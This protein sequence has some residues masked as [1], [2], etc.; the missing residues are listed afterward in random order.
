MIGSINAYTA[1]QTGSTSASADVKASSA[2]EDQN[3]ADTQASSTQT[4][5][6]LARQLAD[7]ASRAEARDKTLSR[8]ELADRAKVFLSEFAAEANPA[9]QAKHDSETPKTND[10]ELQARAKQATAFLVS[11]R[12]GSGGVTNPFTGLSM[13]QLANIAHDDSGVLRS[14]N[15][16]AQHDSSI[17][18]GGTQCREL[19]SGQLEPS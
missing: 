3:A 4:I 12:N 16:A 14:V 1:T 10:P 9:I 11:R 15:R 17:F 2:S 8:S 7:S 19:S 13:E 6:T 18:R 5:S